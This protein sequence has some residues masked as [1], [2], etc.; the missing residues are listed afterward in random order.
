[1]DERKAGHTACKQWYKRKRMEK[2][3]WM[4][5]LTAGRYKVSAL[6]GKLWKRPHFKSGDAGP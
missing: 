6:G 1:M 4:K 2:T 3:T 5:Q